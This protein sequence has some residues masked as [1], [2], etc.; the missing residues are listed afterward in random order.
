M[1]HLER[2]REEIQRASDHADGEVQEQLHSVDE[3]LGELTNGDK[4]GNGEPEDEADR[5]NEL[6]EKLRGLMDESEGEFEESLRNARD[7]LD[8][9]RRKED[10]A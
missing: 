9:Y 2:A 1:S 4:T 10:L 3:G 5:F 7:E 6:E 8:M